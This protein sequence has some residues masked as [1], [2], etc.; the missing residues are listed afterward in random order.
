MSLKNDILSEEIKDTNKDDVAIQSP[1][2][3]HWEMVKAMFAKDESVRISD[4]IYI[5]SNNGNNAI[6]KFQ[7]LATDNDKAAAIKDVLLQSIEMGNITLKIDIGAGT[8]IFH[9][10]DSNKGN[11]IVELDD[12]KRVFV[13][14]PAFYDVIDIAD[15][16]GVHH[17]FVVF[18]REVVSFF[19]DDLTD[20]WGLWNGLYEDIARNIFVDSDIRF[21][22]KPANIDD[23]QTPSDIFNNILKNRKGNGVEE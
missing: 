5:P 9:E 22:T 20:P 16:Y 13:G 17:K 12:Y 6:Y 15:F 23:A 2:V 3:T 4:L 7:I 10:I 18:E 14:N 21:S 8:E 19:N 1:W 11:S